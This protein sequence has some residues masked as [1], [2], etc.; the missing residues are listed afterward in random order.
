MVHSSLPAAQFFL[1]NFFSPSSFFVRGGRG[2]LGVLNVLHTKLGFFYS[3]IFHEFVFIYRNKKSIL[4][5][6][7]NS[8][9]K[10]SKLV[11]LID[12]PCSDFGSYFTFHQHL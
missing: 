1:Y 7:T 12:F 8:K 6:G 4:A 11:T 10:K 3:I 2:L 9:F 5:T